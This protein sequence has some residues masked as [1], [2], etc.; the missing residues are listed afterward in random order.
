MQGDP[1]CTRCRLHKT[2]DNVCI[3]GSGN[4]RAKVVVI[5]EAPGRAEEDQGKPFVGRSGQLLRETLAMHGFDHENV[6]ICNAVS[7]RPPDNRTPSKKEITECRHWLDY[8]LDHVK[9][10]FI[11]LLGNVPLQAVL[12][13]KG[14]KKFRGKPVD[15]DGVTVVPTYHPAFVLRDDKNFAPFEADIRLLREL[16]DHGGIPQEEDYNRREV[17]TE[18]DIREM[19]A[20][21]K[22]A[23]SWDLETSCLYPWARE[24]SSKRYDHPL[25][26]SMGFCTKRHQWII[27]WEHYE[28]E[29]FSAARRRRLVR[30]IDKKLQKCYLIAHNGKFDSLWMK[31]LYGVDWVNDFDTM[32]AHYLIDE[33]QRHGLKL[34]SQIYCGAID[35]DIEPV[36]APWDQLSHYHALDVL[37][38][39]KLCFIFSKMLRR[40]PKVN[41]VFEMLMMPLSEL[42]T[43][44]EYNGVFIDVTKFEDAEAYLLEELAEAQAALD[45]WAPGLNW[46]SPKQIAKL[47]FEDLK[48][49]IVETTKTGAASTSESVINRINHPIGPAI[50]RHRGAA[51]QHSF[52]IEGW[53][54]FLDDDNLLHP[55]FKLHG[56]VT[57]RPSCEHPNLQQVPRDPRIRTLITAPPGWVL[58]ETDLS[59]IELRIAAELSGEQN[60]LDIF[61]NKKDIHWSTALRNVMLDGGAAYAEQVIQTAEMFI[62]SCGLPANGASAKVLLGLWY[63]DKKGSATSRNLTIIISRRENSRTRE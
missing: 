23:V 10:E 35:Y 3:L 22:G 59:Q 55:S 7:C 4:K 19:L 28:N 32:L 34:L 36:D 47:L 9:P 37:Y 8:Q 60:M 1:G 43:Q 16:V 14:I 61:Y 54:P 45:E 56:A 20:D 42:F 30:Q 25:L 39:R 24:I 40:D 53:K 5:G 21:L 51:Q 27:P 2:T 15:K 49:P 38:T 17:T 52:F 48:I 12:G 29:P 46:R 57:G 26:T 44:V 63:A 58:V 41:R 31:V 62:V 50:L 6:Y 18:S 13:E 11:L 33:N